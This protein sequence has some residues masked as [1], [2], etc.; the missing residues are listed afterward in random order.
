MNGFARYTIPVVRARELIA[1]LH[2]E[3]ASEIDIA[4]IAA[5]EDAPVQE[6]VAVPWAVLC[7]RSIAVST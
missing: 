7:Q 1:K 6:S 5:H 2:I 4:L 3:A